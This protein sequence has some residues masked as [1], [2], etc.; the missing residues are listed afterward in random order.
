MKV[1][2]R[3][4]AKK[5]ERDENIRNMTVQEYRAVVGVWKA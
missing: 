2:Y 5:M 3:N 1:R 4:A